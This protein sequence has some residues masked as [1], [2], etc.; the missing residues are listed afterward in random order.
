M[1]LL[2]TTQ[3]AAKHCTQKGRRVSAGH[4]RKL[5]LKGQQDPGPHGPAWVRD[6]ANG[7]CLYA[8]EELDRWVDEWKATLSQQKASAPSRLQSAA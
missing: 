4:L 3:L 1:S 6:P 7:Y 2:V 5:R 8:V